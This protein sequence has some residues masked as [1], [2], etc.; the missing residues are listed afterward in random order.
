MA[1]LSLLVVPTARLK[2]SMSKAEQGQLI[3]RPAAHSRLCSS[4]RTARG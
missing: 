2:F 1:I 3:S 4:Q